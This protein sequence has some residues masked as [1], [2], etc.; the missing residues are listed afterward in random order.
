MVGLITEEVM[1]TVTTQKGRRFF[2]RVTKEEDEMNTSTRLVCISMGQLLG[3][4]E[5]G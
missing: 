2:L 5:A 4:P 3:W 1:N